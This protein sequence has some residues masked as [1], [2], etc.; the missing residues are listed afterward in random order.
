MKVKFL[1]ACEASPTD[2]KTNLKRIK[3][4]QRLDDELIYVFPSEF[5]SPAS[6][7]AL[8]KNAVI[9]RALSQL[10]HRSQFRNLIINLED[11]L[12]KEY[13]DEYGNIFFHNTY[14][15]ELSTT[16]TP[17]QPTIVTPLEHKKSSPRTLAKDFVLEKYSDQSQNALLWIT[18]FE[19][20]C[21]RMGVQS[22]QYPETLRLFLEGNAAT[23]WFAVM[24][25]K[26]SLSDPWEEWKNQFVDDFSHKGWSDVRYAYNFKYSSGKLA[27]FA[28]K[29]YRL[30]LECDPSLSVL[31]QINL[32]V[33]G[34]P[35]FVQNRIERQEMLSHSD[36][37]AKLQ[38]L[39]FLVSKS[40][41]RTKTF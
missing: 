28:F 32:V 36:L 11:E 14:L 1:L 40:S 20:E 34:L 5:Q 17:T 25:K 27:E 38:T 35:E 18:S 7:T 26:K 16:T 24:L 15:D 23:D 39:E 37:I 33:L 10:T 22:D 41:V 9:A 8:T 19:K 31:S 30:L 12:L 21:Q 6:H 29:K 3:Q 2:A 13:S 4:I